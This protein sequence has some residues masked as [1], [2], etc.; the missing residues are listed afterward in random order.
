MK[1]FMLTK[2]DIKTYARPSVHAIVI[3]EYE[4]EGHKLLVYPSVKGWY[5]L[6]PADTDGVLMTEFVQQ[7]D[8]KKIEEPSVKHNSFSAPVSNQAYPYKRKLKTLLKKVLG[9]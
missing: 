9:D 4:K 8:L 1:K 5:E 6:R 2:K 7:C 3:N